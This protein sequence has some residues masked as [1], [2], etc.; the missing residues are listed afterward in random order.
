M[1]TEIRL[2]IPH[3]PPVHGV[4]LLV[5]GGLA[6]RLDLSYDHLEDLQLALESILHNDEYALDQ[7]VG[8]EFDVDDG[9]LSMLIGPL[10]EDALR[11]D[12]EDEDGERLSLGRLLGTLVQRVS[13]EHRDGGAWLR[14]EKELTAAQAQEAG[15]HA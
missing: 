3:R 12:L 11:P 1:T 8:V 9:S 2:S 6:A 10:D 4:A 5:V 13:V 14:L 7:D 15:D